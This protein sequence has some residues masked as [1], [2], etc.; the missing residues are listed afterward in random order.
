MLVGFDVRWCIRILILTCLFAFIPVSMVTGQDVPSDS[1]AAVVKKPSAD[2]ALPPA[3]SSKTASTK[4]TFVPNA[5]GVVIIE[6]A[7]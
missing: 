5:A 3:S 2:V 7:S 4:V 1:Q 6:T